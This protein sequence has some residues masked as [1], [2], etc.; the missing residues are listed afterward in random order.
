MSRIDD[1][2]AQA[3]A[4]SEVAAPPVEAAPVEAAPRKAP[5]GN[6]G[7]LVALFVMGGGVLALVLFSG[8]KEST[9]S[10][11]VA[12]V[13]QEKEKL[14]GRNV[15]VTGTLTK[16]TLLRRDE[17]CEYRFQ[18]EDKDK[19]TSLPVR[20]SQCVVPD[21]FRDVPGMD[22]TVIAEGK[23]TPGGH[24]EASN[25]MAQCPSKYEMQQRAKNGEK[26]PHSGVPSVIN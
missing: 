17:P 11:G 13:V 25:I 7:L 5:K 19:G 1:E 6:L 16:G 22:V 14:N 3:V 23:L 4:E 10:K 21:N 8:V 15:R 24:F 18:I 12:E 20:Y 26:A 9:Y 2:L